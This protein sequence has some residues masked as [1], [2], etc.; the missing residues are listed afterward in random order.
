MQDAGYYTWHGG[1][2]G[3]TAYLDFPNREVADS[4]LRDIMDLWSEHDRP[5]AAELLDDVRKH[6]STGNVDGFA[7]RLET[8]YSGLAHQNLDSEACY[9]AVLQTLV[10]PA[11]R[12]RAGGK[13][14][15][16]WTVRPRGRGGRPHLRHGD[17]AR[18][19]R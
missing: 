7:R 18:W 10:P 8:F 19:E 9:R 3:R 14:N 6:L 4:W 15:V 13:V 17:Q 1:A 11:H 5:S 16:G 12:R 2:D